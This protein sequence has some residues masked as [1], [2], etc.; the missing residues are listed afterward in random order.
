MKA[1][2]NCSDTIRCVTQNDEKTAETSLFPSSP[3]VIYQK[4]PLVEVI[5]QIRFSPILKIQTEPPAAFQ[6]CLR[7][8]YPILRTRSIEES[9][10]PEIPAPVVSAIRARIQHLPQAVYDFVS[11]NGDWTVT[12]TRE[13]LALSTGRYGRW[14]EFRS[15]L[16]SLFESLQKVYSPL[17]ITR[18]GLRYQDLLQPSKLG[19][20]TPNWGALLNPAISGILAADEVKAEVSELFTQ[21]VLQ[22]PG[23][24]GAVTVRHGVVLSNDEHEICYLIDSDFFTQQS[25]EAKDVYGKLDYFNQ[26]SGRLFRWCISQ[27]LHDAMEPQPAAG[28]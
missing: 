21:L 20:T 19:F 24:L 3:R 22:F 28:N 25:M 13:S 17:N 15:R 4:N 26:Q 16:R 8:E 27:Q 2:V 18:V 1:S 6:E 23:G 14:E 5:C 7:A 11:K 10:L 12:L 9:L